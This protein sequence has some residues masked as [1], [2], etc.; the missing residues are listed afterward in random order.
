MESISEPKNMLN[1]LSHDLAHV[2]E[3]VSPS[4][5]AV[6]ARRHLSSS[7]VYWRDGII[8][9]ARRTDPRLA[10]ELSGHSVPILY[11]FAQPR[12]KELQTS[13]NVHFTTAGSQELAKEVAK[14][15]EAALK[16]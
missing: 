10:V 7:G 4:V 9:T 11:A 14:A 1:A 6:N 3:Q 12:L 8:V 2:V 5:V 13:A 16:K 15:V